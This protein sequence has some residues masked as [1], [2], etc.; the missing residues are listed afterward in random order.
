METTIGKDRSY[1]LQTNQKSKNHKNPQ[2]TTQLI[3]DQHTQCR[4][5][6]FAVNEKLCLSLVRAGAFPLTYYKRTLGHQSSNHAAHRTT[7]FCPITS[8][9]R[10][11]HPFVHHDA[12]LG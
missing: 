4:T 6:L 3:S 10:E 9:D 12:V 5:A 1:D 2:P 8:S 11:F 7:L